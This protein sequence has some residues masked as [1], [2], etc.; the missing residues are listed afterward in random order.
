MKR[1]ILILIGLFLISG[2][3]SPTESFASDGNIGTSSAQFLKLGFGGRA[4]AMGGAFVGLADDVTAVYWNPA[5]LAV[6]NSRELCFMHQVLFQDITYEYVAYVHPLGR[7]GNLGGGIAYL[8]M[9]NFTG[10][11][12]T[13]EYTSDFTSSDMIITLSYALQAGTSLFWGTSIKYVV[14]RIED[15][16]AK[17]LAFDLGWLVTTPLDKLRVGGTLQNVGQD[18]KF[19]SEAY[20]LPRFLKFGVAYSD[21]LGGSPMNATMDYYIPSDDENTLHLG[22][23]YIYRNMAAARIGYGNDSDLHYNS[24]LS[25]GV[26]LIVNR[27]QTYKLNYSFHP[28]GALG[29]SHTI[30]LLIQF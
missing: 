16:D 10:R 15:R 8:H 1:I 20:G 14:E 24:K 23:E 19:V 2:S 18:L 26:G 17:A 9:D 4:V 30:S 6:N 7:A 25:F 3:V 21:T 11:D 5:G 13:G 28:Q 27:A 29:D 12:E 22:T